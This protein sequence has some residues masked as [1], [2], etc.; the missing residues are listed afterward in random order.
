MRPS[1]APAALAAAPC[2]ASV[3][4]RQRETAMLLP[5]PPDGALARGSFAAVLPCAQRRLPK[6][7]FT[8][9]LDKVFALAD[10]DCVQGTSP[11]RAEGEKHR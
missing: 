11:K 4:A 6:T 10:N 5:K 9:P 1:Q 7:F 3:P 2:K 8:F